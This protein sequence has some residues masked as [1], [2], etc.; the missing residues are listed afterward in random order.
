MYTAESACSWLIG[1]DK[2]VS[3][4]L[5]IFNIKYSISKNVL[6]TSNKNTKSENIQ[7]E[8]FYFKNPEEASYTLNDCR[9]VS[10]NKEGHQVTSLIQHEWVEIS[11]H[12]DMTVKV[13]NPSAKCSHNDSSKPVTK[14][15]TNVI[16]LDDYERSKLEL[17]RSGSERTVYLYTIISEHYYDIIIISTNASLLLLSSWS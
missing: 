14:D 8:Y 15:R 2:I 7:Q 11:L 6:N 4:I 1:T 10:S 5:A 12:N 3:S 9:I 17:R 13:A 16:K